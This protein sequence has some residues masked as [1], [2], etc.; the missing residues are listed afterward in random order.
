MS[1]NGFNKDGYHK[2]TGTPFNKEGYDQDGFSR[3]GYDKDG[4]DKNGMHIATGTLVNTAGLNKEGNYEETGTPFN[5]EGYHKA[6][7]TKF[8]E[9]GFD[10]DGFDKNGYYADGFNK[11]GYDKDGYDKNGIHI[12]TGTLV[13]AAG[14]NKEGNYEET[15]TFPSLFS[16][17]VLTKVPVT[18]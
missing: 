15:G 8:N 1:K 5:K 4:F 16:P 9:E 10:K 2:T 3:N 18:M 14:L 12:A 7:D 17:A 6:T 13:N 11:N